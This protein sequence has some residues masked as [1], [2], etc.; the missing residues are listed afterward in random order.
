MKAEVIKQII[1]IIPRDDLSKNDLALINMMYEN[2]VFL[3][4]ESLV[5]INV[6]GGIPPA[7]QQFLKKVSA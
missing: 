6:A 1:E 3:S 7:K 5:K 4:L 2:G